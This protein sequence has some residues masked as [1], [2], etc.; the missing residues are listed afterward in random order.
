VTV[1]YLAG[2][3]AAIEEVDQSA[4]DVTDRAS[5]FGAATPKQ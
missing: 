5:R 3:F 2:V 4:A 1:V